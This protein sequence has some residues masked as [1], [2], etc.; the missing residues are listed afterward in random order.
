[1]E[2]KLIVINGKTN[3][4]EVRLRFPMTIG[5][6][7]MCRLCIAH[8]MI[9]RQHCELFE[10]NGLVMVRDLGSLNGTFVG[11]K[12][13]AEEAMPV[14][15]GDLLTVGPVTFRAVYRAEGGPRGGDASWNAGGRTVEG[16]P[17]GLSDSARGPMKPPKRGPDPDDDDTARPRKR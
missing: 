2:A 5:R 8:P 15:P 11:D 16:Q 3:K 4:R 1:M 10:S 14:K 12:R 13:I 9:S 6:G 7:R 17:P